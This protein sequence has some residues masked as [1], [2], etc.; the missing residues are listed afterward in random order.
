[1]VY[2]TIKRLLP[3]WI[4]LRVREIAREIVGSGGVAPELLQRQDVMFQL[5]DQ[6]LARFEQNAISRQDDI[7]QIQEQRMLQIERMLTA[8]LD[9]VSGTIDKLSE[10]SGAANRATNAL[11]GPAEYVRFEVKAHSGQ[12]D[13]YDDLIERQLKNCRTVIDLGCGAGSLL[14]SL[15]VAGINARG[16]DMNDKAVDL[17]V[18]RGLTVQG[19][20]LNDYLREQS[21][22]SVD[23]IT[24][25]HV[26]E[27]INNERLS[28]LFPEVFRVLRSGGLFI[29]ETPK[30]A[31]VATLTQYYFMDPTHN[32]PRHHF[33]Y[34]FLVEE[35]GF[36][37]VAVEDSSGLVEQGKIDIE[38]L[39]RLA[40]S[41]EKDCKTNTRELCNE[42]V[43]SLDSIRESLYRPLDV[44][45]LAR[46]P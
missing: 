27:H 8:R 7:A 1:M 13:C 22:E 15:A 10:N 34:K 30:I 26:V 41:I 21:A 18:K 17:C 9:E 25:L 20:D 37:P 2:R 36:E 6:R 16:V 23:A 12:E 39:R 31:S 33:L 29:I 14:A 5:Y 11:L 45:I 24:C 46:K 19:G 28:S 38:K 35:A 40:D 43:K 3:V 32:A 44:R 42:L 4:K